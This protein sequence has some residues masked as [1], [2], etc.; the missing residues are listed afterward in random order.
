MPPAEP[1]PQ[2]PLS[3]AALLT[4]A[5][6]NAPQ[7]SQP[8]LTARDYSIRLRALLALIVLGGLL[9]SREPSTEVLGRGTL[10][11]SVL[12]AA[13]GDGFERVSV[14]YEREVCLSSLDLGNR[15]SHRNAA[16][17]VGDNSKAICGT[18]E[19]SCQNLDQ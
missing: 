15:H 5:A 1:E 9:H 12:D 16:S 7:F 3:A 4:P 6:A 14:C 18:R 10:R 17:R 11:V 13:D 2:P 8:V 19:L